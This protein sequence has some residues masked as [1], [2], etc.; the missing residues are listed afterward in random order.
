MA[1]KKVV[2]SIRMVLFKIEREVDRLELS[3]R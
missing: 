2:F 3:A 1:A